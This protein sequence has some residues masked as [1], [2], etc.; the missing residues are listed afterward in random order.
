MVVTNPASKDLIAVRTG[1]RR[2][3]PGTWVDYGCRRGHKERWN[4][5]VVSGVRVLRVSLGR[6]VAHLVLRPQ[7]VGVSAAN[8][9]LRSVSMLDAENRGGADIRHDCAVER[10]RS[11]HGFDIAESEE[12]HIL[13]YSGGID[14][15]LTTGKDAESV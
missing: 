11:P 12:E 1:D 7:D 13:V 4:Q 3:G 2:L 15:K 8:E 10:K 5:R 9:V 14:L 6:C